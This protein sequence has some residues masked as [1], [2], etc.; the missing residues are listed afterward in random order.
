MK[1]ILGK[2]DDLEDILEKIIIDEV[3]IAL[4]L[5][6][7]DKY[8]EIINT[9]DKAGVKALIIPDYFDILPARP[10]FD[11]FAG[12]PLINVRDV[13]L[14]EMRDRMLKRTFDIV[15]SLFVLIVTSPLLLLIA[16]GIKLTSPGPV[17]FKQERLGRH[18]RPF[19][20]YT[21]SDDE[22]DGSERIRYRLDRGER[23]ATTP[24]ADSCGGRAWTNCR[25]SSM[26]LK[27][28]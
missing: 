11:H 3:I 23:S 7:H 27:E 25:S 15:F 13:P 24:S 28:T 18:R 9:C 21:V 5:H 10:Y 22:S 20:M 26:C 17:I 4:P 12:I 8:G 19:V 16:I 1:P 2:V 14:D 6:A